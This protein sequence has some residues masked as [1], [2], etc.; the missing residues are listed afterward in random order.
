MTAGP[1]LLFGLAAAV[2]LYG[3]IDALAL[4]PVRGAPL[5]VASGVPVVQHVLH[6][7]R[8]PQKR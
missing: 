5:G 8:P 2:S 7:Q 4:G 3:L 1:A 6:R